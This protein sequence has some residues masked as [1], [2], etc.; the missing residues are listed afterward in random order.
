MTADTGGVVPVHLGELLGGYMDLMD[1]R[2]KGDAEMR[3]LYGGIEELDAITG[4]CRC[5]YW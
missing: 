5:S 4:G 2:M 3:N 1:R